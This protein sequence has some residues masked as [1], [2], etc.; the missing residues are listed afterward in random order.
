MNELNV[1]DLEDV[2]GGFNWGLAVVVLD[3]VID[4]AQGVKEGFDAGSK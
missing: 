4:F 2:N 1:I 3:A